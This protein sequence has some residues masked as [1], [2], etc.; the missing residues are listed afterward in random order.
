MKKRAVS[1]LLASLAVVSLILPAVATTSI[2]EEETFV[3]VDAE[4]EP[5]SAICLDGIPQSVEY[6]IRDG[7]TYVTVGSFVSML[8]PQAMVE[9][10]NGIVTVSSAR[11][12][13]VVDAE[14]NTAN[15]VQETLSM[16]ISI[17]VPYIV[18]NG[19]YL[20][21]KD[22]L[23]MLNN[24]VA[25]PVRML[26]KVFN[27]GVAYDNELQSIQ[28]TRSQTSGAYIQPG[29][30]YYDEDTLYWLSR[31]ISAES[32]NQIL[33]GKIAVGNV[34][35]NR[36]NSPLFPDTIY[37]VLYQKNQFSPAG[38]GTLKKT[39][40]SDSVL[41]AKLVM[42]GTQIVPNA[43]FFSRAGMS[44]YASKNRPYITTI[45]AHAFYA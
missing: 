33:E 42:D 20:Y 23:I 35:L 30:S 18:A 22:S 4:A 16:T 38:N 36:V 39:P 43:L 11:V 27:L 44:C 5:E 31:I 10:E 17:R 34:V 24:G 14:G 1:S 2:E 7:T 6:E 12:E 21:A 25:A 9:E 8:D 19:R 13:Q 32:G 37:D 40:N 45:G 3:P 41:A 29:D 26:A 15:V 28:L